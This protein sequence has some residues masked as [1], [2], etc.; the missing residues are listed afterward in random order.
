MD[1]RLFGKMVAAALLLV[2]VLMP[3][4]AQA[5]QPASAVYTPAIAPAAAPSCARWTPAHIDC[6]VIGHDSRI[7]LI[8]WDSTSGWGAWSK[9]PAIPNAQLDPSGGLSVTVRGAEVDIFVVA[10]SGAFGDV[11]R[12]T[13]TGSAWTTWQNLAGPGLF[14]V[15]EISCTSL[16]SA[17]L[18]C[19]A[20]VSDNHLWK[21]SWNGTTWGAWTDLGALPSES[22]S[23]GLAA[24]TYGSSN[25]VVYAIGGDGHAYRRYYEGITW[26]A[27]L[28]D[29]TP[30]T[31]LLRQVGCTA[32][33]TTTI[34]CAFTDVDGGVWYRRWTS[35][36]G[37]GSFI[38]LAFPPS[39]ARGV[40]VTN[41][42]ADGILVMANASDGRF[43]RRFRDPG[44]SV[45]S[46]WIDQGRP[47]DLRA[48]LPLLTR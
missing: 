6:F 18:Q 9:V 39:F 2:A 41:Y 11:Y 32:L 38:D 5:Q 26:S 8:A 40:T 7:W 34:D 25:L 19:F 36:G 13:W 28:D 24:T 44:A 27:W 22:S 47:K 10:A 45:W 33:S 3:W 12:L 23:G 48:F 29:G 35:A 31:F 15:Y 4:R 14:N 42:G 21:K 37:W 1:R 30:S 20:R 17:N 43:Y 16:A 46:D